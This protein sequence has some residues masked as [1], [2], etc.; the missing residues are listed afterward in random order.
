MMR[1]PGRA[2]PVIW[3]SF[4]RVSPGLSRCAGH[5][6]AAATGPGTGPAIH[7]SRRAAAGGGRRAEPAVQQAD[8]VGL[9]LQDLDY[10]R[11]DEPGAGSD[12][13]AGETLKIV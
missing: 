2:L 4:A 5:P 11:V 7:R 6:A 9:A 8:R 1:V 3:C 12:A 10:G 13:E